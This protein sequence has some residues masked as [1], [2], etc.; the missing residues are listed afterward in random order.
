MNASW[1]SPQTILGLIGA[2]GFAALCLVNMRAAILIF[3]ALGGIT[4]VQIGAFSGQQETQGLLLVEVLATAMI[5]VWLLRRDWGRRLRFAPFQTPL[6][7]M[8]PCALLSL[9]SGFL[10]FDATIPTV[11]LNPMVSV[12]QIMLFVWPIGIYLV[13]ANSVHDDRTM[14]AIRNVIVVMALPATGLI[15][16]PI[17]ARP[18]FEWAMAFA[19]PASSLCFAEYFSERSAPRRLFLLFM[20]FAPILYGLPTGK[21]FYYGYVVV[22]STVIAWFRAPRLVL[23]AA[24]VAF[25]AYVLAVPVATGSLM[26]GIVESAVATEVEQQSLGGSGGRWQLVQDGVGIWLGH[27]ILG[28]GPGNN[29]P[30]MIRYSTLATPHNQYINLLMELGLLGFTCFAVFAVL[31]GRMGLRMWRTTKDPRRRQLV[32]AWLGVFAGMMAGGVFGDFL[33][34]SIRNAGL[35]LFALYY[36]QW[37]LLGLLVSIHA[38]ERNTQPEARLSWRH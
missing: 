33:L 10:W 27:P 9:G 20:T 15:V 32:L 12:G 30:Y 8:V 21:A 22:S 4:V 38:L 29:Y 23:A 2:L 11:H 36:V 16:S 34:P 14:R 35:R 19:L 28:V 6:L 26:P 18:Y 24:P 31:A 3:T 13:I 17:S 7:L 1:L 5:G 25:A 37:V